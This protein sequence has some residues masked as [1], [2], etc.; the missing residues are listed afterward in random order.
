MLFVR[1]PKDD[2]LRVRFGFGEGV[3]EILS[4]GLALATGGG[5][6]IFQTAASRGVDLFVE[7]IDS[8][9]LRD[10]IPAWY[11][12][13]IGSKSA[14]LL[15]IVVSGKTIGLLYGDKNKAGRLKFDRDEPSL[16][17]TLRNQAVIAIRTSAA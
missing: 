15:P 3:D 5:D 12:E 16:L 2:T 10:Q 4:C 13:T 1:N 9:Q 11:R 17:K 8:A 6:D 7:D 14:C